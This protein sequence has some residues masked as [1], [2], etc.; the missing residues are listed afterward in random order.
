MIANTLVE[1]W[2]AVLK[3]QKKT[4]V[5]FKRGT[6]VILDPGTGDPAVEAT[7]ILRERGKVHAGS[8]AGDFS[9]VHLKD[10]PGWVVTSHDDNILTYVAQDEVSAPI[11]DLNVGLTGR[12]KRDQDAREPEVLHI[13]R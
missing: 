8:E 12:S 9:V 11:T 5:V 2:Q 10:I 6:C 13:E 3:G 4:W 7:S 1:A